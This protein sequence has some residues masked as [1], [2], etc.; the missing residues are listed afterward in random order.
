MDTQG[1][2]YRSST[3]RIMVVDDSEDILLTIKTGLDKENFK[4]D[5]FNSAK[6][7]LEAFEHQSPDYDYYK[8]VL[9][10]IRMPG[11]NGFA[12]YVYLKEKNPYMKIAFMTA[13]DIQLEEYRDIIPAIEIIDIIK[14]PFSIGDLV[15][16]I[17][18]NL[19]S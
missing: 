12:L 5:I 16:Q 10:D 8:L 1:M 7:A 13:C 2:Q 6:S 18:Y 15:T 14:K 11:M 19:A 9:T 3:P 17:R 4:I